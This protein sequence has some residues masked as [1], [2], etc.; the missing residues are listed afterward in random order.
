M[1]EKKTIAI[2]IIGSIKKYYRIGGF[3]AYACK[4]AHKLGYKIYVADS[5]RITVDDYLQ[6]LEE[7]GPK[8]TIILGIHN[9][10]EDEILFKF[11]KSKIPFIVMER[12][13]PEYMEVNTITT[14]W[15]KASLKIVK[16]LCDSGRRKIAFLGFNTFSNTDEKKLQGF[17]LGLEQNDLEFDEKNVFSYGIKPLLECINEFEAVK[18]NY[19]AVMCSSDVIAVMLIRS[20]GMKGVGIPSDLAVTGFDNLTIGKYLNPAI[21]SVETF[22]DLSGEIAVKAAWLLLR[23]E[24]YQCLR[25][26][27]RNKIIIR[28]SSSGTA[29][30]HETGDDFL[31]T[32]QEDPVYRGKSLLR[33]GDAVQSSNLFREWSYYD[34]EFLKVQ[35]LDDFISEATPDDVRIIKELI[36]GKYYKEISGDLFVPIR[37]IKSHVAKIEDML[38]IDK[39]EDVIELVSRYFSSYDLEKIIKSYQNQDSKKIRSIQY[40]QPEYFIW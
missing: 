18:K 12:T 9:G 2:Y 29:R 7:R 17:K 1:C 13:Y 3:I 22:W 10:C 38:N 34:K 32:A 26:T 33:E 19:D 30:N 25:I 14:N 15:H 24:D 28:E 20:E 21:T 40:F 27:K 35:R 5:E 4:T 11:K 6:A 39:R 23:L 16:H 36:E 37:T 31:E 8:I